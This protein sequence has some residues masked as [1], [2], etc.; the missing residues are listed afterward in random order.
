MRIMITGMDGYL[1]WP[2]AVHLTKLGHTVGGVDNGSRRR[3]V[4]EIGS[5][6]AVPIST[7]PIRLDAAGIS[8]AG[9]YQTELTDWKRM[10]FV[11]GRFAPDAIIYLGEIP[12]APYSMIDA[13]HAMRVHQNNVC[14]TL[15]T[16]FAMRDVCPEA[17]LVKLG[18]M[19][20]YGTPDCD[21]PEGVFPQRSR[22]YQICETKEY[23]EE[24]PRGDLSGLMFPRAAGSWYHQTKVHDSHNVAF[25]CR[26]WGLQST[27]IMQGVVYG[28]K[29]EAMGDNPFLRT[30]YDF[31]ECF[32]TVIHR[33]CAQAVIGEPLTPFG[34]GGQ[35]RGFLPLK[36]V[37]Q[38]ITLAIENPPAEGEYRTFNQFAETYS[39]NRLAEIVQQAGK[40]AGL[41]V[42]I[43]RTDNPR[44]E[45]EQHQYTPDHQKLFALGYEPTL[46]IEGEMATMLADLVQFRDRIEARKHKLPATI[47]WRPTG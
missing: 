41:A 7:M 3:M 17:H 46:D 33:F 43:H 15:A 21:I 8:A 45:A 14:G 20:E 31:D 1:G 42:Q 37:M 25:A 36:D 5:H 32:G 47:Q 13:D 38:C 6:S 18:T 28:T 22:W 40:K 4:E 34:K 12:S 16:L 23:Y 11:Y 9:Y 39:V 24:G 10:R 35:I 27:D 30:R 44:V 19:G 2:L 26:V 29:I